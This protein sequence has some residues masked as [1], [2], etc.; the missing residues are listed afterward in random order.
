ME[1]KRISGQKST[2]SFLEQFSPENREYG[3]QEMRAM[4]HSL[5]EKLEVI[6]H[7]PVWA[8]TSMHTLRFTLSDDY[9]QWQASVQ[10]E[11]IGCKHLYKV[12]AV[13]NAP[14]TY[15]SSHLDSV[16]DTANLIKLA[17]KC[18]VPFDNNNLW[19]PS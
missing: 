16:N 1:I 10:I 9:E 19:V 12:C 4:M 11:K 15:L 17:L 14:W 18:S 8:Y 2:K 6:D 13:Q 5:V 7:D 3:W